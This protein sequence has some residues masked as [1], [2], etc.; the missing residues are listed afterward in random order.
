M[1]FSGPVEGGW[2][3]LVTK[4]RRAAAICYLIV[5]LHWFDVGGKTNDAMTLTFDIRG[6]LAI[7]ETCELFVE[8]RSLVW[9][10]ER[11]RHM[12]STFIGWLVNG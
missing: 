1:H 11:R 7:A 10:F 8:W 6:D 12:T 3:R 5:A 4:G 2:Y 9:R